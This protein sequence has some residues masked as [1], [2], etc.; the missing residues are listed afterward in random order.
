V[1]DGANWTLDELVGRVTAALADPAYPGAPNGRVRDLPDRRVIRWYSTIGLVDRPVMQGRTALYGIRH[2]IQIVAVKRLQAEGR[3]LADIQGELA[4]APDDTLRRVAGVSDELMTTELR[5]PGPQAAPSVPE[6]RTRFWADAPAAAGAAAEPAFPDAR[7]DSVSTLA[8][9]RLA[10]GALILLPGRL[11]DDDVP[12]IQ[13]AAQPL[14]DLLA[15][16]GLLR[17][18]EGNPT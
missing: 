8:A 12:A 13:A 10:G 4:G 5:S 7:A 6:R 11:D 3:S 14:V 15:T 2:L 9:V 18:E 1:T 16:R 17:L